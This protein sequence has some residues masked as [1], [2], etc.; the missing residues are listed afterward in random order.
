MSGQAKEEEETCSLDCMDFVSL[1]VGG[2]RKWGLLAGFQFFFLH[3]RKPTACRVG[4]RQRPQRKTRRKKRKRRRRR[5]R[6][7]KKFKFAKK[8]ARIHKYQTLP[9]ATVICR[10]RASPVLIAAEQGQQ[11]W[12][13]RFLSFCHLPGPQQPVWPGSVGCSKQQPHPSSS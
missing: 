7:P 13:A 8:S 4:G 1:D 6:T 9:M 12:I 3:H 5:F 10:S 11:T 2:K